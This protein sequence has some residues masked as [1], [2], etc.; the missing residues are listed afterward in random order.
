MMGWG[1]A[2]PDAAGGVI[3]RVPATKTPLGPLQAQA[4]EKRPGLTEGEVARRLPAIANAVIRAG[5]RWDPAM[6][7]PR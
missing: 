2:T 5:H 6:A 1:E 7:M 3:A 4:C